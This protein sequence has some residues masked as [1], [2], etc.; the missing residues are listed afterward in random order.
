LLSMAYGHVSAL[1]SGSISLNDGM[2]DSGLQIAGV[3]Y[4]APELA[5]VSSRTDV[6]PEAP[7]AFED[8]SG[9]G[10]VAE[11]DQALENAGPFPGRNIVTYTTLL[12]PSFENIVKSAGT[13]PAGL[14]SENW[15]SLFPDSIGPCLI[16]PRDSLCRIPSRIL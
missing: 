2:V 9:R 10:P 7:R 3:P 6:L 1:R 5:G 14:Q 12:N 15:V 16:C 8:D 11:N 4:P 13:T